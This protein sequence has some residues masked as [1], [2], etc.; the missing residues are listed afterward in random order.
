MCTI[1]GIATGC[2]IE[3]SNW[4]QYWVEQLGT[5]L[6]IATGYSIGY[7]NWYIIVYSNCVQYWV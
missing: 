5:V 7:S 6:C 3:Y 2:I 4:V 1:L